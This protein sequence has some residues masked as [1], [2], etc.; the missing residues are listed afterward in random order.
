LPL[1]PSCSDVV[2]SPSCGH[3]SSLSCAIPAPLATAHASSV[4]VA[5]P[6]HHRSRRRVLYGWSA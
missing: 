3:S 5:T 2:G 6:L 4:P 1:S